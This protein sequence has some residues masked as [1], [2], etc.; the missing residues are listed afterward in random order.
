[1]FLKSF[2]MPT[3]QAEEKYF[4][5]PYSG[6]RALTCYDSHYP[7]G[8]FRGRN[9]PNF[10]MSDITIF[11]GDNGSGKSTILNVMAEALGLERTVPY[12]RSDFFEDYSELC[13]YELETK[14][15]SGSCIIASDGVF[16]KMLDIRRLNAG[17]DDR[18][19]ELIQD[20]LE[21]RYSTDDEKCRLH[22]LSDYD[23]WKRVSQA[24][25]KNSSASQYLRGRLRRNVRERSNGE[26]ALSY[27]VDSIRN[28]ALYLLDE[29]ENSLSPSNQLEF[30][31]FLEDSVRNHGCQF[32]ISTHSPFLLSL[33]HARIYDIDL[34]IPC[35][36]EWTELSCVQ[37]YY[38]FFKENES[39][40]Q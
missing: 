17:V 33:R 20:Y 24:R 7:F 1:M 34:T 36:V 26:S 37:T 19:S 14:I 27:F 3:T 11:C 35:R 21:N 29:P 25:Q 23:R 32:V 31:Y 30:K 15:P 4:S 2:Q 5:P 22:G 8:L 10:E 40:L 13:H 18:R 38:N 28:N 9:L 16:D 6:K 12:N 39:R